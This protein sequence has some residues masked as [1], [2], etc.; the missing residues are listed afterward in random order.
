MPGE[1]MFVT[2]TWT[3]AVSTGDVPAMRP[4]DRLRK[5]TLPLRL[6]GGIRVEDIH[7]NPTEPWSVAKS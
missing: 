7:E 4:V 1:A 3:L 2:G 6:I 5:G